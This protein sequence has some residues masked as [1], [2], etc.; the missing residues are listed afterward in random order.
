[1]IEALLYLLLLFVFFG[2]VFWLLQ[3]FPLPDPWGQGVYIIA[4]LICLLLVIGFFFGGVDLPR[5]RSFR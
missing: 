3:K 5:M 1:M 4:I 2:L